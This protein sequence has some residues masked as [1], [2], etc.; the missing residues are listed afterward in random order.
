M[1]QLILTFIGQYHSIQICCSV[2]SVAE[3]A[4][5]GHLLVLSV[6]ISWVGQNIVIRLGVVLHGDKIGSVWCIDG[7]R[8]RL[9]VLAR[10][11]VQ[12]KGADVRVGVLLALG[13]VS[14]EG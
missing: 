6:L 11:V 5:L 2:T 14:D 12:W 10:H 3:H 4:S 13:Q 9:E 7:D 1:L 8:V